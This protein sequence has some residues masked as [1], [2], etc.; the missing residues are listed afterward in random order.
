MRANSTASRI[1]AT[2]SDL[3][4]RP[5]RHSLAWNSLSALLGDTTSKSI[6]TA[7]EKGQTTPQP[8]SRRPSVTSTIGPLYSESDDRKSSIARRSLPN[9]LTRRATRNP[10]NVTFETPS[11]R[12]TIIRMESNQT[13]TANVKKFRIKAAST[14]V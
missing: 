1:D 4:A 5:D 10:S 11:G 9:T 14:E 2:A 13:P 6:R 3:S 12:G 8:L 7:E